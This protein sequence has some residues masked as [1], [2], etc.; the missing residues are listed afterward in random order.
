MD[1]VAYSLR[2]LGKV[3]LVALVIFD[4]CK[5]YIMDVFFMVLLIN[6]EHVVILTRV[7]PIFQ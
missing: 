1:S 7:Q 5:N 3:T 6:M 4:I 2:S